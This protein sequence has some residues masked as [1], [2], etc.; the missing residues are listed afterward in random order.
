MNGFAEPEGIPW[1]RYIDAIWRHSP[2]ILMVALLGSGVGL[3][4][5]R[6]VT[7]V[8]DADATIWINTTPNGAQQAGP[9]RQQQLLSSASWVELLRSFAIVDPIVREL[10]LNISYKQPSD[11]VLFRNFDWTPSA[12]SGAYA[13]K[14]D[15]SG[16]SYV[17]STAKGTVLERGAV[18]DSV[19]RKIGLSWLPDKRFLGPGRTI[20]FGVATP[21]SASVALVGAVHPLLPEDGQFL[22]ITLSGAE[23]RR[24]RSW[25]GRRAGP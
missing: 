17:L 25:H 5:A 12:R 2:L 15:A 20:G 10:K 9:I 23:P 7:P 14:V 21:R 11:S 24:P 19:G 18:G 6:W 1:S 22:K 4:A 16:R 13:L 3:Y 8:Y